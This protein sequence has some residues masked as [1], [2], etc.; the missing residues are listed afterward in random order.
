MKSTTVTTAAG[1]EYT[2]RLVE[3]GDPHGSEMRLSYDRERP[4]IEF[5]D[6]AHPLGHRR[7]R[8]AACAG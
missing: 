5:Y 4:T 3:I 2:V 7:R 8:A 1:V 6:L